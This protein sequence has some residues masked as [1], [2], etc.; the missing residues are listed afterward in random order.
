MFTASFFVCA[1][2]LLDLSLCFRAYHV[3]GDTCAVN[4]SFQALLH[5]IVLVA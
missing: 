3:F 1:L 5:S 2:I 4:L